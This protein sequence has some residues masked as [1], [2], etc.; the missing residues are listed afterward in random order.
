MRI[1][2]TFVFLVSTLLCFDVEAQEPATVTVLLPS[3]FQVEAAVADQ[4]LEALNEAV[5]AHPD[6]TLSDIPPQTLSE[7]LL[8]VGCNEPNP[9]CLDLANEI[10]ESDYL[11]WGDI[12]GTERAY[13]VELTMWD[14]ATD[15][16][17]NR[18]TKAVDGDAEAFTALLPIFARGIVYGPVGQVEITVDPPDAAVEFDSRP[19]PEDRPIVL[20]GLE[21]G[22]HVIRASRDGYF[23]YQQE[24][25]VDIDPVAVLVDMVPT[26]EEIEVSGGRLWTWI[27]LGSGV[28]LTG[29][30][31]ALALLEKDTQDQFDTAAGEVQV[32][33]QDLQDLQ[34][35]GE[36]EALL[37][38]IFLATGGAALVAGV[39]LFF[40]EDTG[41]E[42][43]TE[44]DIS[45]A[46]RL[47]GDGYGLSID[48]GF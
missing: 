23:D 6:Y 7:L 2:V 35:Q 3:R 15:S 44:R 43:E 38:N 42:M 29:A 36:L 25:V 46:P 14:F 30:G 13:L 40:V 5:R 18:L 9:E 34:D 45:V 24:L 22:P 47:S 27:A 41:P 31:I 28:A 48:I 8:A 1:I 26:T 17:A 21:L 20:Q 32:N 12:G 11:I 16:A 19:A 10:L 4:L 39:V 37:A 33:L